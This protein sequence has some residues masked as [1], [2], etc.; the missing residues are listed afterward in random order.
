MVLLARLVLEPIM[1]GVTSVF[2]GLV[3]PGSSRAVTTS[4]VLGA[5]YFLLL[6]LTANLPFVRG[7]DLPDGTILPPSQTLIFLFDFVLPVLLPLVIIGTLL[8]LAARIVRD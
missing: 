3:V 4:L 6:N 5:F 1:L 2:I 7:A 8:P